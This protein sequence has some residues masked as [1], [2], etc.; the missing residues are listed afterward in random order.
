MQEFI[1]LGVLPWQPP[2]GSKPPGIGG[3]IEWRVPKEFL[4]SFRTRQ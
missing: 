2:A 1:F 3:H 4:S